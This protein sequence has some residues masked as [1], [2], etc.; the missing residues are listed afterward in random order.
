MKAPNRESTPRSAE[1][2]TLQRT[3]RAGSRNTVGWSTAKTRDRFEYSPAPAGA[4]EAASEHGPWQLGEG[5]FGFLKIKNPLLRHLQSPI[6]VDHMQR[7][8][9]KPVAE[10]GSKERH[11]SVHAAVQAKA[12]LNGL[13]EATT[14]CEY[15]ECRKTIAERAVVLATALGGADALLEVGAIYESALNDICAVYRRSNTPHHRLDTAREELAN[16]YTVTID[17][18]FDCMD[19]AFGTG[20]GRIKA[21]EFKMATKRLCTLAEGG[22]PSK[23]LTQGIKHVKAFRAVSEDECWKEWQLEVETGIRAMV[24]E[25]PKLILF[26]VLMAEKGFMSA[27]LSEWRERFIELET[28]DDFKEILAN[29]TKSTRKPAAAK[30]TKEHKGG[31]GKQVSDEMK[32]MK[33]A[34]AEL[35]AHV[36]TGGST[37]DA[38]ALE[39]LKSMVAAGYAG[40][41]SG[42]NTKPGWKCDDTWVKANGV[43]GFPAPHADRDT[44]YP[45]W[46]AKIYQ[47][48]DPTRAAKLTEGSSMAGADC[49]GCSRRAYI[50]AWYWHPESSQFKEGG[51]DVRPDGIKKAAW[52]HST[53]TCSQTWKDAHEWVRAHP[54]DRWMFDRLPSGQDAHQLPA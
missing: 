26:K 34:L 31:E 3:E 53:T 52:Y 11:K 5:D 6:N 22:P 17:D 45:L 24:L 20:S 7:I 12:L 43:E 44:L 28:D 13:S 10:G 2:D 32:E 33:K 42:T 40:G 49:P 39:A 51:K 46:T 47:T 14:Q 29:S 18:W 50:T 38:K 21:D 48:I 4:E 8:S 23:W 37:I 9:P 1:R 35:Q 15:K 25:H 19:R 30:E 27:T 16:L 41:G 54:T 36:N